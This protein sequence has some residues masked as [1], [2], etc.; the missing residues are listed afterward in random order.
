VSLDFG[1]EGVQQAVAPHVL[2]PGFEN[3]FA[4]TG[5]ARSA[6]TYQ[7]SNSNFIEKYQ[8]R[9]SKI[10][11]RNISTVKSEF[12]KKHQHSKSKFRKKHQYSK[13]QFSKER[14]P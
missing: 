11:V 13:S 14:V 3:A 1:Q 12:R 4:L 8:Y 2:L 6:N 10:S 5:R 7:Y 9:K